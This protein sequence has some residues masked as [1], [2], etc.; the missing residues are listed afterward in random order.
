[1]LNFLLATQRA[2]AAAR[3][4]RH[5]A[6]LRRMADCCAA[7][8]GEA[9]AAERA[10]SPRCVR[11][12]LDSDYRKTLNGAYDP[13]AP[14]HHA[15]QQAVHQKHIQRRDSRT[16]IRSVLGEEEGGEEATDETDE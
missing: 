7:R 9:R 2:E 4:L 3:E 11:D 12:T 1:M 16:W 10:L 8:L 13:Q 6:A 14:A 15:E 5:R